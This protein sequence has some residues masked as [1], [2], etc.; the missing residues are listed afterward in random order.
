MQASTSESPRHFA[1]KR[2]ILDACARAAA[3][4]NA[5]VRGNGWRVDVLAPIS[6]M[7]V[8]FEGQ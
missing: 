8:A 1:I 7:S 3:E 2:G 6:G 4:A 5:E